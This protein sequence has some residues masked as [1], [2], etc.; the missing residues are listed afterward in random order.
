MRWSAC[1]R[2]QYTASQ[3]RDDERPFVSPLRVS[4]SGLRTGQSNLDR[5]GSHYLVHVHRVLAGAQFL[6]FDVEAETEAL[7]TLAVA[8][9]R[10]A[11]YLVESVRKSTALPRCRLVLM[12]AFTKGAKVDQIVRDA[13][14]LDVSELLIVS[15]C[16]S[17]LSSPKEIRGRLQRWRKI[18]IDAARQCERGNIPSI[19]GVVGLSEA[20]ESFKEF[21][22]RKWVLSPLAPG[23][24][25]D[26]LGSLSAADAALL[27]GPEGGLDERELSMAR[28]SGFTEVR[29]GLR[30][31]R[32]ETAA[33]AALGAIAAFRDRLRT[34][35][36]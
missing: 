8:D 11:T 1:L 29:L 36:E 27:I 24:L 4:V 13:T 14:A 16:R 30:I 26:A 12:Q 20:L 34:S 9:S 25:G 23:A 31:M 33:L 15:T 22:G 21:T 19:A 32:C 18:A 10:S 28:A 7:A 35:A 3:G 6:A 5:E 17:S 2:V